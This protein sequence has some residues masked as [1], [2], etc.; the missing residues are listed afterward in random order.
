MSSDLI[1]DLAGR[2]I[3]NIGIKALFGNNL[4]RPS[5]YLDDPNAMPCRRA[6]VESVEIQAICASHHLAKTHV[7]CETISHGTG[8]Q[9]DQIH[10]NWDDR[11]EA[12]SNV[13]K[14]GEPGINA[15]WHVTERYGIATF[16]S[17]RVFRTTTGGRDQS[18]QAAIDFR[19][20]GPS[21]G[22]GIQ[23]SDLVEILLMLKAE[24]IAAVAAL[25][26]LFTIL[27]IGK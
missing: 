10:H 25:P 6:N 7:G 23:S 14:S 22:D 12:M 16:G 5:L 21:Y 17:A 11:S 1:R 18:V 20:D 26:G 19:L 9:P 2:Q 15:Q 24:N 8:S 27:A 4:S 3:P 13:R